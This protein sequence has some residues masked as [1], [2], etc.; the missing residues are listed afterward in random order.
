MHFII[1]IV[2]LYKIMFKYG[3]TKL[4]YDSNLMNKKLLCY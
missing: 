2:K 3:N 1:Y 4:K